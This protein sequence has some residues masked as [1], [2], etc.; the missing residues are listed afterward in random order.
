MT[1]AA[2]DDV[3]WWHAD[4]PSSDLAARLSAV[5]EEVPSWDTA[6]RQWGDTSQD[7]VAVSYSDGR[8][9]EIWARLDLREPNG[10]LVD[11][12]ATL[13]LD[14]DSWWITGDVTRRVPV[15]Q[16]REAIVAAATGSDA[17]HFALDPHGFLEH[18][19]AKRGIG[20]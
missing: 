4:Q 1:G 19:H 6:S 14:S 13:A 11:V 18:L 7:T 12:L 2:F 5:L 20:G 8:V 3:G 9:D 10:V 17:A 16:T 15:G